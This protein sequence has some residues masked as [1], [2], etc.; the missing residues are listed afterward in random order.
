MLVECHTI[1]SQIL[2]NMA[3]FNKS[4]SM[5]GRNEFY[6]SIQIITQSLSQ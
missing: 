5:A 1:I 6:F 2:V 4:R 3:N